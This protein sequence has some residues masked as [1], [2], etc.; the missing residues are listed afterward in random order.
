MKY[1][2][3]IDGAWR[4]PVSGDYAPNLNPARPQDVLG[5][6]ASS[7]PQDVDAAVDAARR[8]FADFRFAPPSYRSSLLARLADLMQDNAEELATIIVKEMGKV[9]AEAR[10]EVG[11]AIAECRFMAG[12]ALHV[13]GG[14]FASE[15]AGVDIVARQEP[16]GP[17][18]LISPWNFPVVTPIR[19]LAPAIAYGCT[20]VMKPASLTP[21]CSV[22][23]TELIDRAGFPKGV[24]NLVMGGGGAVGAALAAHPAIAGVSFTGSTEVGRRIYAA[25]AR[26][27]ARVQLELGGKNPAIVIDCRDL[28]GAAKEIV[29]AAFQAAGQ[30]C[31]ALS[32]VVVADDLANGLV[33]ELAAAT[34]ELKV[35]EGFRE[36]A[37]I[38]PMVSQDQLDRVNHYMNV[39]RAGEAELIVEGR[40][41]VEDPKTEGYFHSPALF[42]RVDPTS[43]LAVDEIF[44]PILPVIRVSGAEQALAIAND[45]QYGLAASLFTADPKLAARFADRLEA[46]MVHINHGTASQPHVPFGGVK[47]SGEGAYSIGASAR[48][49]YTATKVVYR[50]F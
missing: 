23:L 41:T 42:D 18:A 27:I 17:V 28:K 44:G 31:T 25:A 2:N 9:L 12:E 49:F 1:D 34:R 22:K 4:A 47:K 13:G 38:G 20:L 14:S 40:Q 35:A 43:P 32:R 48:G 3:Y 19:K 26:R 24:A 33:A 5:E 10:G 36:G 50:L 29:S 30:R 6:F 8:A 21:W 7:G 37:Q 45:T 46:G 16:L 15:R 11:R 39:G